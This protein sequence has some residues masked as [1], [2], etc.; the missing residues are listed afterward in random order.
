MSLNHAWSTKTSSIIFILTPRPNFFRFSANAFPSIRSIGGAPSRCAISGPEIWSML[1]QQA[2]HL[3]TLP[4]TASHEGS[5]QRVPRDARQPF[6]DEV[7]QPS[8]SRQAPRAGSARSQVFQRWRYVRARLRIRAVATPLSP[9]H[10]SG[11]TNH[12]S[13]APHR[14]REM[15]RIRQHPR[16]RTAPAGPRGSCR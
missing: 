10:R 6:A 16:S 11:C 14:S 7:T 1:Q 9:R 12:D 2:A 8:L 5:S 4:A 13:S 15:P 3:R